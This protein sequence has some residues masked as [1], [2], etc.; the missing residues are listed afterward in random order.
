M[1]LTKRYGNSKKDTT[2]LAKKSS[3]TIAQ[4]DLNGVRLEDITPPK[5]IFNIETSPV[6]LTQYVRV[7]QTN[8]RQGNAATKTRAEVAGTTK[9]YI[10]KR[11]PVKRAMVHSAPLFKGG[12]VVGGPQPKEYKLLMNKKQKKLALFGSLTLKLKEDAINCLTTD[13][14]KVTSK[15]KVISNFLN[16]L[17]YEDMKVLFVLPRAD[18]ENFV[19]AA[20]NLKNA[21]S[22]SV[23]S[24]NAYSVLNTAKVIFI[25][26]AIKELENHFIKKNEN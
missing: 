9:K 23:H 22:V 3:G 12:G 7:H 8:Q 11:A 26:D 18:K 13:M 2:K 16:V 19:L 15:T 17:K 1:N 10:N 25:G 21:L 4:Y 20:R 24:L 5:E 14:K 6:L